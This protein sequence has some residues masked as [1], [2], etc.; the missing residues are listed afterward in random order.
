MH[1]IKQELIN[2]AKKMLFNIDTHTYT[3]DNN[4]YISVTTLIKLYQQEFDEHGDITRNYAKKTG[5]TIREVS[6]MWEDVKVKAANKGSRIHELAENIMLNETIQHSP[7][8]QD[9][10]NILFQI[11]EQLQPH[12]LATEQLIFNDNFKI[13]GTVDILTYFDNK[14]G[15]FDYKTNSKPINTDNPF[16]SYMKPPLQHLPD[17]S[18][19]HYALQLSLYRYMLEHDGF[20]V[21]Q[22]ELIHLDVKNPKTINVPY[23]QTEIKEILNDYK[24]NN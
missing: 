1:Q 20:I 17:T 15:I 24:T 6:D 16:R 10:V 21:D 9:Y 5:M 14:I 7:E 4:N 12:L 8:E 19:Y 23:L 18:Y 11:K 3:K 13:A 2:K 22:L